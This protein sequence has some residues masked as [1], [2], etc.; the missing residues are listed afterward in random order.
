MTWWHGG[1]R[2]VGDLVL[3]AKQTGV[4]PLDSDPTGEWVHV[5]SSRVA[6]VMFSCAQPVP[7][8]YEVEPIGP[9][10]DD[11]DRIGDDPTMSMR[12]AS[13]RIVRRYKPSNREIAISRAALVTP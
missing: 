13:A 7:W 3:P 8:I 6:A 5:T 9:L 2:I 4:T 1:P 12:C 11:P 10:V